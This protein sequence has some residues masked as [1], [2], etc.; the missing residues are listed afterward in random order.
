MS[1]AGSEPIVD[2]R[3]D[4]VTRPGAAMRQA[5]VEA[6]V[7]D[8][9]FYDDPTVNRL[10]AVVAERFGLEAAIF[11][12]SGTMGNQLGI[13]VLA[14]PGEVVLLPAF[15]HI[16]RWEGGG[17]AATFGVQ[18][19]YLPGESGLPSV[20]AFEAHRYGPHPKAPRPVAIAL[21]NT[22]NWAGG[23]VFS[24]AD[25]AGHLE[26]AEAMGLRRHLDGARIWNA[27]V[28]CG[29]T[30]ATMVRGFDT[31][32]VCFSKGLGAPIGS[33]VIGSRAAIER[34]DRLRQRLGGGWRQAGMLAAAALW[35]LEHNLARMADD[36]QRA[37]RIAEL[38]EQHDVGTPL[39]PIESNIVQFEVHPRF[40][41][42]KGLVDSLRARGVV[43][44]PTGETTARLVTHLDVD[45]ADIDVVARVLSTL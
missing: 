35:A 32:S 28:A 42:A 20:E 29:E 45:D 31:V 40:S 36:H 39:H 11:V 16:A 25:L 19:V 30:A 18:L 8:A 44:F 7:G 1:G 15:A 6:E 4:T 43:F 2:L 12:P 34:A 13:G 3:S 10:E 14:G 26:W 27:M 24:P 38:L 33:C 5:M 23:R 37:R 17:S 41:S 21:E 22:H 9:V